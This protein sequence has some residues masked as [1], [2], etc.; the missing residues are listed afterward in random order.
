MLHV[1]VRDGGD[2]LPFLLVHGLASNARM[3]DGVGDALARAGHPSAA[4]DLRGHGASGKPDAG[5]DHPTMV[6]DLVA[7]LDGLGWPRCVAAGQSWGGAVVLELA[8]AHP[9]RL[10]GVACIDGGTTDLAARHPEWDECAAALAP[11]TLAG[12]PAAQLEDTLR[13]LHGD[14]PES[15]IRGALACFEV[16]DDGTVAPWL[17]RDRHLRILREMWERRPKEVLARV[18]VPVLLVPAD[19]G[20]PVKRDEVAVAASML[21]RVRTCW[22]DAHHDVH[23]Q[24]PELVAA[25]LVDAVVDGFFA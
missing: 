2:R 6:A 24:H 11:P 4:V 13:R 20:S 16:R 21:R 17:T 22:V 15:G 12:T 9:E 25:L 7:V 5:Y 18:D 1:V 10:R 23:A 14:W 3:W 19:D 8:A